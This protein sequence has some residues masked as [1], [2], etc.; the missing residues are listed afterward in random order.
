MTF[1]FVKNLE[2]ETQLNVGEYIYKCN[3]KEACREIIIHILSGSLKLLESDKEELLK[4]LRDKLQK[5]E[6]KKT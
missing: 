1:K 6:N 3:T 5:N 2:G 4:I